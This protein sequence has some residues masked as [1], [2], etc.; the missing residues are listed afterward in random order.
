[1]ADAAAPLDGDH[2]SVG[3][4]LASKGRVRRACI[5][6][7][8]AARNTLI[9]AAVAVPGKRKPRS[10]AYNPT[11]FTFRTE[12]NPMSR[13]LMILTQLRPAARALTG[14]LLVAALATACGVPMETE[15]AARQARE[16]GASSAAAA[17]VEDA[18]PAA[19]AGD[20]AH[21]K[22]LFVTC[23]ACH[24]PDAKGLPN[25]GKDITTSTFVKDKT[26][27]ELVAFLKVGRDA[28][29]PLNTTGVAMP[30]KGGNPVLVDADLLDLVAY[31]RELQG[32][33]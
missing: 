15:E 8:P 16:G 28:G 5:A 13:P 18:A 7:I 6:A 4:R 32:A 29:D 14:A 27:D 21:G 11:L 22:E 26:D 12:E 17:P 31:M 9:I 23:A 1:M 19:S 24:G 10:Q 2:T 33:P 30:P 25:L 3:R 20:A